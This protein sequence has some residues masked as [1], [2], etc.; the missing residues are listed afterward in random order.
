MT[1]EQAHD[2]IEKIRRMADKA[3]RQLARCPLASSATLVAIGTLAARTGLF[4]KYSELVNNGRQN[5]CIP[6]RR[7][8]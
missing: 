1:L 8:A 2:S 7:L 3:D 4:V 6:R 5:R